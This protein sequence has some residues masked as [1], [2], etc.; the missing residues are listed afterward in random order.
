MQSGI[1]I[2]VGRDFSTYQNFVKINSRF[3][4]ITYLKL[5]IIKYRPFVYPTGYIKLY[6]QI[7]TAFIVLFMKKLPE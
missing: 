2:S 6:K 4:S 1:V 5:K 3:I 7:K